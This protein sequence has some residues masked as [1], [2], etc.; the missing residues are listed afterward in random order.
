MPPTTL[1][2]ATPALLRHSSGTPDG[3][4]FRSTDR[5]EGG[6]LDLGGQSLAERASAGTEVRIYGGTPMRLTGVEGD[7]V[8]VQHGRQGSMIK[9]PAARWDEYPASDIEAFNVSRE[10]FDAKVA[11][12]RQVT[13]DL[14]EAQFER[15]IDADDDP[16]A[17]F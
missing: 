15:S 13:E 5:T 16:F 1:D 11:A 17:G 9:L 12:R 3:G 7:R 8:L 10:E 4:K 2:M 14:A 6:D